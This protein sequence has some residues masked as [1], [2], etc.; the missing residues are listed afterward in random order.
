MKP[1]VLA[2]DGSATAAAAENTAFELAEATGAQLIAVAVWDLP[3]TGPGHAP[4][5]FVVDV[6]GSSEKWAEDAVAAVAQRA[7]DRDVDVEPVV[8]RGFPADEICGLA[9]ARD[10][11]LIV[12]GSHGWGRFKRMLFGSVSAAV[13]RHAPCPVLIVPASVLDKHNETSDRVATEV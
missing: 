4:V 5:P 1:I 9:R 10:A 3:Y 2:T 13:L 11:Q 6:N 8:C 12:M 7:G